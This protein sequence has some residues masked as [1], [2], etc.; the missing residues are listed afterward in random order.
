VEQAWT[1]RRRDSERV[2]CPLCHDAL[3][4]D[5]ASLMECTDCSAVHHAE[6]W[7]D[8]ER[9]AAC[10]GTRGGAPAERP[11]LPPTPEA[12]KR[13]EKAGCRRLGR[14]WTARELSSRT[15][16]DFPAR[17]G[18]HGAQAVGL[19]FMGVAA[20]VAVLFGVIALVEGLRGKQFL[21]GPLDAWV[22]FGLPITF[23]V[24]GLLTLLWGILAERTEPNE[25]VAKLSEA[26]ARRRS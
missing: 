15:G 16:S 11:A 26:R 18:P 14:G 3:A 23:A 4:D 8:L 24:W 12:P 19:G 10:A 13:C 9:C 20:F 1:V 6:C 7:T 5:G 22:V 17:C 25:P 2:Q 21:R